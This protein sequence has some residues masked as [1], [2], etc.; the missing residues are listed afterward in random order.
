MNI[1]KALDK[2]CWITSEKQLCQFALPALVCKCYLMA[3]A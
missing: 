3:C 2:Y 1:F